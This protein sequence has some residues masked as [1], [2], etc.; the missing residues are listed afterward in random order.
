MKSKRFVVKTILDFYE[1]VTQKRKKI[2]QWGFKQIKN[3]LKNEIKNLNKKCKVQMFSANVRK[4][5][6]FD[7]EQ[8]I[9]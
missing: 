8:Q 5:K 2:N 1:E 6:A 7:A 4:G 9:R 3:L